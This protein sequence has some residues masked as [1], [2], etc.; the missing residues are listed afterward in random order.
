MLIVS[1]INLRLKHLKN[2]SNEELT[3]AFMM[4]AVPK[5][6]KIN[7]KMFKW[8]DL[9]TYSACLIALI[10][11]MMISA[12]CVHRTSS[13][14]MFPLRQLNMRMTEIL[15]DEKLDSA[16]LDSQSEKCKEIRNLQDQF[17]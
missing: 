17:S 2:E 12:Y 4:G 6:P 7:V 16:T 5:S 14:V 10:L 9:K 15:Q 13:A 8:S 1:T 3:Y 11:S